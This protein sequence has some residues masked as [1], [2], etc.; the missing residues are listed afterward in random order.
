[1]VCVP[2]SIAGI[3]PR[4]NVGNIT[5]QLWL[6]LPVFAAKLGIVHETDRGNFP[7]P[8]ERASG[9]KGFAY[10]DPAHQ[11]VGQNGL[12]SSTTTSAQ[13]T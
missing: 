5:I 1:M 6:N 12:R 7:C 2:E 8:E 9:R 3:G 10:V 4:V 11:A 13:H